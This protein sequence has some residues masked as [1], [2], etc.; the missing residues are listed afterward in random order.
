MAIDFHLHTWQ[1]RRAGRSLSHYKGGSRMVTRLII[2]QTEGVLVKESFV[3]RTKK[4]TFL[5]KGLVSYVTRVCVFAFFGWKVGQ[6]VTVISRMMNGV[7]IS[8]HFFVLRAPP[9]PCDTWK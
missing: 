5:R 6:M 3:P 7:I 9:A 4:R 1:S 8:A 2:A